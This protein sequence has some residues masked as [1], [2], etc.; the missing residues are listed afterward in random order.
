MA[1]LYTGCTPPST[2]RPES[3][4]SDEQ[5]LDY[6][7]RVHLNYMWDGAEPRSGMATERIHPGGNPMDDDHVVTTGGT[8]F[9][10]AGL[11]VGIERGFIPRKQGVKRLHRIVDFLA[12]AERFHGVWPH[13]IDSRTGKAVA[14]TPM[15]NGADLVESAFMIQGLICAREYFKD[16]NES[17][18]SLAAKIDSL[19]KGMEWSF[20]QR[21]GKEKLYWH[22][23]PDYEWEMNFPLEGYNECLIT[24]ILGASS[25]TYPIDTAVY[26]RCWARNGAIQ[27]DAAPYGYKLKLRHNGAEECGG[28]LFWAHYSYI[29]FCPKGTSDRYADYWDVVCN[30]ALSD[31]AYCV[32]NPGGFEGYGPDCWGLTAS[33][34]R[35]GYA[36]H[37]PNNDL[38]E[39]TPTAALSSF[40]YTPEESMR[41]LKYFYFKMGEK[42]WGPYGFFDAFG[43]Q[44]GWVSDGYLAID[45]CTIAP[46]IENYRTGLLWRLFMGAPEIREGLRRLDFKTRT[47]ALGE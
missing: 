33:Y 3:F 25:P 22:W 29:G 5:M 44:E 14:F 46:M 4:D 24:Y 17:E 13:W 21:G 31:Y 34:S 47:N 40:P 38:G 18:R 28:P 6:I 12:S 27:S 16:G 10:V 7:Q 9:G 8:G 11:I 30:H 20:F 1:A 15:D 19:W 36:G 42:L 2:A 43:E 37:A 45:Q 23:S 39:I 35:L 41:A 26:H 32:D